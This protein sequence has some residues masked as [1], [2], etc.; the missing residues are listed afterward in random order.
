MAVKSCGLASLS[1]ERSEGARAERESQPGSEPAQGIFQVWT[2][3]VSPRVIECHSLEEVLSAEE[4][5]RTTRFR[6][7][8]DRA[9]YIVA[10]GGLR[11]ILSR[12]FGIDLASRCFERGRYGKPQLVSTGGCPPIHFSLSHSGDLVLI[13]VS[14]DTEIGVDIEA[15]DPDLDPSV[16]N[17]FCTF[18]ELDWLTGLPG[19]QRT[20]G[21]Y[22][23][24]TMKEALA[25]ALG[26]GA[27]R[28]LGDISIDLSSHELPAVSHTGQPEDAWFVREIESSAGYVSALASLSGRMTIRQFSPS[29]RDGALD[30][31]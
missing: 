9:R 15:I 7:P 2:L 20:R 6:K 14:R 17:T 30:F 28:P 5:A 24:W 3:P 8:E 27:G 31:S 26:W 23:L 1:P 13:G 18:S 11:L 29:F 16:A 10:H 4:K 19:N 25:K 21:L 12:F 22:R